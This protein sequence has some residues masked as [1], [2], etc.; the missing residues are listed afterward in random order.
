M[1]LARPA[2]LAPR[3]PWPDMPL[4]VW[5]AALALWGPGEMSSKHAHHAMHLMFRREGT[6]SLRVGTAKADTRAAGILVGP[7]VS[8]SVDARGGDVLLLFV[9]PESQDG[10]RLHA[11]LTGEVRLFDEAERDTLLAS[12]PR[13]GPLPHAAV[14]PWMESTLAAL[15]GPSQ[16]SPSRMHPRV[17]KLLRHLRAEPAP[18]DT[19]LETLSQVAGLSS[20]RLMHVF[21]ESTGVPLRPYLLWLKLQRSAGAI[22]AGRSLGEAAHAAGF[23]DAAHLTR[24]FRR[25]FGTAPSLLQRRSQFVQ[26]RARTS[27]AS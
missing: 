19:S 14:G 9:E 20:G 8:H 21:T 1:L 22:A 4:V 3:A 2:D 16:A 27:E 24:T 7:D 12:L 13:E 26:A 10:V 18:D 17:R 5:P 11:S 25:M 6:L 23:S 15:A